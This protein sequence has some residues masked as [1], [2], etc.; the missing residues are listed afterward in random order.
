LKKRKCARFTIPGT[1]LYYKKK[2]FFSNR[3]KYS[4]NYF[5]VLDLSKGGASF[6]TNQRIKIGASIIVKLSIPGVDSPLEILSVI[7]WVSR[8]RE[9]SYIYQ[10]GIA[11]NAYGEKKNQ[12]SPKIL[13]V[14]TNLELNNI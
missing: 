9:E 7:K 12:N 5:P 14:L 10:T 13:E 2:G 6:L 8:N 11:F 4:H 3:K 1:T